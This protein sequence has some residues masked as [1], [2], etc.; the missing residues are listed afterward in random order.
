MNEPKVSVIVPVYNTDRFLEK[1]LTSIAAQNY[2]NIEIIIINDGSTDKSDEIIK[3]FTDQE[4]RAVYL[5]QKN[6]GV[7]A[8]RNVGLSKA[9]GEYIL[10]C[11]S[12]D[13]Y[14]ENSVL[15]L[16]QAALEDNSDVVVGNYYKKNKLGEHLVKVVRP[17]TA[18]DLIESFIT[19]INHAS[20]CNKLY[21]KSLLSGLFFS[22][23]VTIREDMLFNIEVLLTAPR[24]SFVDEPVYV[25]V[26]RKGS[27]V[28]K[29]SA[30]R[31][32]ESNHVTAC[33]EKMLRGKVSVNSVRKMLA[34]DAYGNIVNGLSFTTKEQYERDSCRLKTIRWGLKK[35]IIIA[36]ISN[37]IV[38]LAWFY[39]VARRL[40]QNILMY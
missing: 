16:V 21:R 10:F 15:A 30:A 29:I 33:L 8:A 18:I 36:I 23:E 12:D 28:D 14:L 35:R 34:L 1:C 26:Q 2:Q 5:S 22:A 38:N 20:L 17:T 7:S 40:K 19:G 6:Q 32:R 37:K 13:Y 24:I 9:T 25:Y 39:R 4:K 3:N 11:D 31:M 27:A